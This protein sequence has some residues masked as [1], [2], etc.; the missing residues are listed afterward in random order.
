MQKMHGVP[1]PASAHHNLHPRVALAE[2]EEA[3]RG[4]VPPEEGG[5]REIRAD[6]GHRPL[7]RNRPA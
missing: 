1:L 4:K 2:G 7:R 6:Q 3:Q 5:Q